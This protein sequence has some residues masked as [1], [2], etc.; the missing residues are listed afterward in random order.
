MK[1]TYIVPTVSQEFSVRC[2]CYFVM[3]RKE[4]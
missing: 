2:H 4:A 3:R 1:G